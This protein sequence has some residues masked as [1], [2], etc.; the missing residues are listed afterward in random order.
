MYRSPPNYSE[1]KGAGYLRG[2]KL[3]KRDLI[4]VAGRGVCIKCVTGKC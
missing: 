4:F 2:Y 1:R 3:Q